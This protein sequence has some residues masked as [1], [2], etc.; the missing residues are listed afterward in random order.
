[1]IVGGAVIVGVVVGVIVGVIVGVGVGVVNE[2]LHKNYGQ[3]L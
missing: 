2:N 3:Q 1:V